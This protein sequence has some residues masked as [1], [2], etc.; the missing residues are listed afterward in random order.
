MVTEFE[1]DTRY[2]HVE[3]HDYQDAVKQLKKQLTSIAKRVNKE[4][5]KK[6]QDNL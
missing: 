4:L 2:F 1:H 6:D 3:E 5:E